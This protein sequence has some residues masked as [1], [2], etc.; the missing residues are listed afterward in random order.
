M[1]SQIGKLHYALLFIYMKKETILKSVL[2]CPECNYQVTE[3]M[4]IDACQW[5]YEC[6]N[7]SAVIKPKHGDCCVFCSY[8][9][10]ACPS[11]QISGQKH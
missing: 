2:T 4:P 1:S 6:K 5:F 11:K 10:I 7:C 8:G 9:S 3:V